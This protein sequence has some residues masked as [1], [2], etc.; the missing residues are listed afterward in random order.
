M[1]YK[2]SASIW[3]SK[4]RI[5]REKLRKVSCNRSGIRFDY[6]RGHSVI[7]FVAAPFRL[8]RFVSNI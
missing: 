8:F 6:S 3:G 4:Q 1:K 5:G 2:H 7:W